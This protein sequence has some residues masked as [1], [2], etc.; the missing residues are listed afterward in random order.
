M[1]GTRTRTDALR[2]LFAETDYTPVEPAILQPSRVF[3]DL[4][5]EDIRG[6]MYLSADQAG[7]E[8]CLRPDYTIP[9]CRQHIADG[10]PARAGRY[11]YCGKVFRQRPEGTGEFLQAGVECLGRTD[12]ETADADI[13]ALALTALDRLGVADPM[14]QIGDE[15]LFRAVLDGL[16]LPAAWH[17]RLGDLFGERDE[18]DQAIARMRGGAQD[19]APA[20]PALARA[21]EGLDPEAARGAVAEL[22]ALTG[23][24]PIG[25]RS[26]ED[27][28]ERMLEQA[29]LASH[30]VT[31]DRAADVLSRFLDISGTP[32]EALA[33]LE[34]FAADTGLD[35]AAPLARFRDRLAALD[36]RGIALD[37]LRFSA[38][39][40]R[41]LDYYTGFVFEIH[42]RSNPEA[43][44][45][46][47]GGRYDKLLA[48]LGAGAHVPATGFS[49]WLDRL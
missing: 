44:Q 17:R 25:G 32:A 28:A 12:L 15:A 14:I 47:G 13:F 2:K 41:R 35:L 30:D 7:E 48:L 5:G 39:F 20:A 21:L 29:A 3:L 10:D 37:G 6:R 22:L 23:L 24:R 4:I 16:G 45:L 46:I 42:S 36:A 1:N 19:T 40:G 8:L 27:I 18:L 43:G 26:T 34:R 9:V 11:S 33:A 31:T 49:I 38:D